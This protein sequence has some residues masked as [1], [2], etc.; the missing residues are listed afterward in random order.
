MLIVFYGNVNRPCHFHCSLSF[1][2]I[3][4]MWLLCEKICFML[5]KVLCGKAALN[6]ILKYCD[7]QVA[8][9]MIWW[10]DSKT[11]CSVGDGFYL[12]FQCCN[13]FFG[14]KV[15]FFS[16]FFFFVGECVRVSLRL[17]H[18]ISVCVP[19]LSLVLVLLLFLCLVWGV[20]SGCWIWVDCKI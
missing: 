1:V 8:I 6:T 5:G 7:L 17:L 11:G 20:A 13:C 4:R 10:F 18:M 14:G 16:S 3:Y 2:L 12:L 19:V 15:S 9:V